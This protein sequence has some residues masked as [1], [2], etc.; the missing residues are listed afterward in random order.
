MSDLKCVWYPQDE[1]G[2]VAGPDCG[3]PATHI[4]CLPHSNSPTCELH[5]CKCA[6]VIGA[7]TS[8][9]APSRL[10]I[11][12]R[13]FHAKMGRPIC[14]VPALPSRDR[15]L[16]RARLV[17][18][19][20]MEFVEACGYDV[21]DIIGEIRARVSRDA[22]FQ[23]ASLVDMVDA[24]ADIDYVVEGSRLELGVDGGPIADEVHRT[25]MAK[26][27]GPVREAG[28]RLKPEGWAPADIARE[29][30]KQGWKA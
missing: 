24:L 6:T 4:S 1:N 2:F 20:A 10:R 11:Q 13:E 26:A 15:I 23:S 3:A 16:L 18:E 8:K 9:T 7:K 21:G 25:N 5:K 29:L 17:L 14:D 28:K 30:R 19:E 22:P 12:L 27:D